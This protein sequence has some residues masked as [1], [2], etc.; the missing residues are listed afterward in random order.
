MSNEQTGKPEFLT[1]PELAA[2]LRKHPRT[3]RRLADSGVIPRTK[4]GRSVLYQREAVLAAL[5][6]GKGGAA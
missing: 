2:L 1:E 4:L 3:I 5:P 6:S